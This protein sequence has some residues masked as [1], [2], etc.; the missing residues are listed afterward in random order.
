MQ[1]NRNHHLDRLNHAPDNSDT[2]LLLIDVINDLEF[3]KGEK[4][5]TQ[6]L[7][8]AA[9]LSKL[10]AR[11]KKAGIPAI[12]A[13]DNFGR[14]RSDFPRLVQYCL[15]QEI[16]GKPIVA[17]LVPDPDDYF[18]LKPKHS[19]FYQTNLDILLNYLGVNTLILTGMAAD[20]CVLFTVNDAYMRDL[21]LIV[22]PDCVASEQAEQSRLVL[23]LMQRVLKAEIKPSRKI[24]FS[25]ASKLH[26]GQQSRRPQNKAGSGLGT[27][28]RDKQH[29]MSEL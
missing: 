1:T 17:Q 8:M 11:A 29:S 19:A 5:L 4:L 12:Y 16:R 26:R 18:V 14:W 6:A 10:K 27:L 7:P 21:N 25:S 28:K 15:G 24:Q 22:P 23:K 13:N 20:I 3:D 2:A 9:A